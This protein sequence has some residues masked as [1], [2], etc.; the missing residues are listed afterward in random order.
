MSPI[1]RIKVERDRTIEVGE[2]EVKRA[3]KKEAKK[4]GDGERNGRPIVQRHPGTLD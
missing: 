3:V 2:R 4:E 1:T